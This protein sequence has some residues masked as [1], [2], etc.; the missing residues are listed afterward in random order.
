[1]HAATE[2]PCVRRGFNT[3]ADSMC[4]AAAHG[5][6][7]GLYPQIE[8]LLSR[9]LLPSYKLSESTPRG[10]NKALRM[11]T[12]ETVSERRQGAKL[13]IKVVSGCCAGTVGA[14]IGNPFFLIKTRLQAQSNHFVARSVEVHHEGLIDAARHIH[15][16]HGLRGFTK[17]TSA[18]LFRVGVGSGVQLGTYDTTKDVVLRTFGMQDG[19]VAHI[20]A[21]LLSGILTVAAMNPFDVISTR[22]YNQRDRAYRNVL[23][24]GLQTV[25]S[26]GLSG[27]YKGARA[28]YVRTGPHT[29]LMFL[30]LEQYRRW[31]GASRR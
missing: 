27:L 16:E 3:R 19:P 11:A 4:I 21:S 17:G 14:V 25:R 29:I 1:M 15:Q 31:L 7:L 5:T 18:A 23:D 12:S 30:F 28:Q 10:S 24:C 13:A 8:Q 26:E 22:L 9:W 6:R 20:C 2:Y